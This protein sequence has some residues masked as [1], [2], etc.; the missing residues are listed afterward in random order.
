M[1]ST[2]PYGS[3]CSHCF[4]GKHSRLKP[5]SSGAAHLRRLAIVM[6]SSLSVADQSY[7]TPS[8]TGRPRSWRSASRIAASFSSSIRRIAVSCSSRRA[9]GRE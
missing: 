8:K 7:T 9:I 3:F 4:D 2:T 5:T 1:T 6:S